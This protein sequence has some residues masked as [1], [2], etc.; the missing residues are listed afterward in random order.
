M[1]DASKNNWI[2]SLSTI[3]I[4]YLCIIN[5]NRNKDAIKFTE[6]F[7]GH[8]AVEEGAYLCDGLIACLYARHSSVAG[9]RLE[10]DATEKLYEYDTPDGFYGSIGS[11]NQKIWDVPNMDYRYMRDIIGLKLDSKNNLIYLEKEGDIDV[12]N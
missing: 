4:E 11:G 12:N 8:W 6:E 3:G 9:G 5:Q 7:T 2:L 1:V 10:F